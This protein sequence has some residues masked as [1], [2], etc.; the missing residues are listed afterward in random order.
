[1]FCEQ[2]GKKLDDDSLF[3]FNCGAKLNYDMEQSDNE[4]MKEIDGEI[5]DLGPVLD[6]IN[7]DEEMLEMDGVLGEIKKSFRDSFDELKS[8]SAEVFQDMK[9]DA[10]E[11]IGANNIKTIKKKAKAIKDILMEK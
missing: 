10:I 9:N 3:C 2:C 6:G 1:M 5:I 7:E 8:D 11:M 4:S